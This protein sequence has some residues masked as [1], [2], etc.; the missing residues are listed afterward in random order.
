MRRFTLIELLV[1]I[2]IIAIL[3]S[4]L[5]PALSKARAKAKTISCTSNQKNV[6]LAWQM[7]SDDN[8]G[9]I[10]VANESGTIWTWPVSGSDKKYNQIWPGFMWHFGYIPDGDMKIIACPTIKHGVLLTFAADRKQ[11]FF[12]YGSAHGVY[13]A[14]LCSNTPAGLR[15]F[16]TGKLPKPAQG[17]ALVDT[18]CNLN[19]YGEKF[20]QWPNWAGGGAPHA[21]HENKLNAAFFDGHVETIA[22][23][24]LRQT[25]TGVPVGHNVPVLNYFPMHS[26]SLV[27]TP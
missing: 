18:G 22:M 23:P 12:C 17:P 21:R 14:S 19:G 4:M 6:V 5:L 8:H 13:D 20:I 9:D 2:A 24:Q 15:R 3:A 25:L 1:V 11:P 7:Y 16:I 10:I 27:P 26:T